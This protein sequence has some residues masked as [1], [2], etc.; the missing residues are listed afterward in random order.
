[1]LT[2]KPAISTAKSLFPDQPSKNPVIFPSFTMGDEIP[3]LLTS[4]T[5]NSDSFLVFLICNI[6]GLTLVQT[7]EEKEHPPLSED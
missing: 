6:R 3:N 1:M 5:G 2:A 4:P 7:M